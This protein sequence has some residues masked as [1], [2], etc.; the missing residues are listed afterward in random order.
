MSLE[1]MQYNNH[2]YFY[3]LFP[4]GQTFFIVT[5]PYN[6][7]YELKVEKEKYFTITRA[8]ANLYPNANEVIYGDEIENHNGYSI[9]LVINGEEQEN[10]GLYESYEV[11]F[12]S[13][14]TVPAENYAYY[15][16][17]SGSIDYS[18]GCDVGIIYYI[19]ISIIVN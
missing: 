2:F 5:F 12:G 10:A 14:S 8:Q 1:Y 15:Y 6:K 16:K 3:F 7:N 19:F 4:F 18:P 9:Y 17:D 11:I 13:T